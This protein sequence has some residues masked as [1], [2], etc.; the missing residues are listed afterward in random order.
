MSAGALHTTATVAVCDLVL[1]P[2][3]EL[4]GPDDQLAAVDASFRRAFVPV[5]SYQRLCTMQLDGLISSISRNP[6]LLS[7]RI[8]V[9]QLTDGSG[10]FVVV[11]G[12]RHV[13][14]LRRLAEA[15]ATADGGLTTCVASLFDAC[16]VLVV[17]PDTD[18]AF[19]LALL[20]DAAEAGDDDV[21]MHGQRDHL[22][23]LLMT[24]GVH[25]S[26][27]QVAN[28]AGDA[29]TIRRYYA[30]RALEQM[31]RQVRVPV[32]V[33]VMIYPLLHAAVGRAVI[34]DWLDWDEELTCF[35]NDTELDRF[36]MLLLPSVSAEGAVRP[37]CLRTVHDIAALCDVLAEPAA[38]Q[39]LLVDGASLEVAVEAI[40]AGAFQ[41]WTAHLG[42]ASAALRW[43]KRRFG[44][45]S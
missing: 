23:T 17:H 35:I 9:R 34:C 15:A 38:R 5:R 39:V 43:E 32:P 41:E 18:P 26:H 42:E 2:G 11:D 36:Y 24:S 25:H 22:L 3:N 27:A 4:P 37:P 21:W 45:R 7:G 16:P 40:N 1:D 29:R 20:A 19:V 8:L 28:A 44:R 33:A 14:A 31:M 6:A 12:S 30:Y 13:A 10:Q